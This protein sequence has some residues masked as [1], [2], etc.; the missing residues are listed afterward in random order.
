MKR[1][2]IILCLVV[3]FACLCVGSYNYGIFSRTSRSDTWDKVVY[4]N[5]NYVDSDLSAEVEDISLQ[6]VIIVVLLD[7]ERSAIDMVPELSVDSNDSA[8]LNNYLY[9]PQYENYYKAYHT[10][11]NNEI[12]NSINVGDYEER[13]ISTLTPFV[14]YTYSLVQFNLNKKTILSTLNGHESIKRVY[15]KYTSNNTQYEDCMLGGAGMAGADQDVYFR[16]YT[17][18]GI[19][20]GMLETGVIDTTHTNFSGI[21]VTIHDQAFF[22]ETAS[23]HATSVASLIGGNNGI[24]NEVSFY[25]SQIRGGICE[26]VDWLVNQGV[27]VIN[28]SFG[29]NTR[30]GIYGSESAYV[31]YV[32]RVYN[33]IFVVAAGNSEDAVN[34]YID[35]P[36]LAYNAI[37][38]GAIDTYFNW[39]NFSC[40]KVA[41][42]PIKPTIMA[43]GYSIGVPNIDGY[44]DGTSYSAAFVTGLTAMILERYPALINNPMKYISLLTANATRTKSDYYYDEA[45]NFDEFMGAGEF[46]YINICNNYVDSLAFVNSTTA[47]TSTIYRQT[48]VLNA[49]ETLQASIAWFS[50]ADEDDVSS[51]A[52]TDYDIRL[53]YNNILYSIGGTTYNNVEMVNFTATQDNSECAI[54][55]LQH[56]SQVIQTETIYY[57]YYIY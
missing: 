52:R 45:N 12:I 49:G 22:I 20:V 15:V 21:S 32:A 9:Q 40:Y 37:T 14:E 7:Y 55:I 24:A 25:S 42:G 51:S 23:E 48:F 2:L 31:D 56:S 1:K 3:I 46:S 11:K 41:S 5:S 13:Y 17:G 54:I 19:K 6:K 50:Y 33:Q 38:V 4:E 43:K 57:S 18:N 28:M 8:N 47:T 26:E 53:M 29:L 39:R 27:D 36:G 16:N 10:R 30:D 34:Y 44:I 35:D